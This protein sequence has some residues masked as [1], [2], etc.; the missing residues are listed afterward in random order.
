MRS[1]HV[2]LLLLHEIRADISRYLEDD[3]C[4]GGDPC[5]GPPARVQ[6]L[7]PVV[8]RLC[9]GRPVSADGDT[10]RARGCGAFPYLD[11]ARRR[12]GVG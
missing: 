3:A 2:T 7:A 10:L 11:E 1:H 5:A 8:P 6:H 9:A 12:S 4:A